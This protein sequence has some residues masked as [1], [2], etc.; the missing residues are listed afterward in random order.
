MS[1]EQQPEAATASN[2]TP[3]DPGYNL[4]PG[5][6]MLLEEMNQQAVAAKLAVYKLNEAREQALAEA[7]RTEAQFSGALE[8]AFAEVKRTESQF[9]GALGLLA[10]T[11]GMNRGQLTPDFSRLEPSK[12]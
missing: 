3:P 7:K 10:Y 6:K 2:P 1:D 4:T 11:H 9:S 8:Q 5:E 12:L